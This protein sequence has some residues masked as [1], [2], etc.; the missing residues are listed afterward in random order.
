[1]KIKDIENAAPPGGKTLFVSGALWL[2]QQLCKLPLDQ[3]VDELGNL[4]DEH[5]KTFL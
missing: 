4:Y 1:M 2:M 3:L 5:Q